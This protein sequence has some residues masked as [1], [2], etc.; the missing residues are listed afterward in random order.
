MGNKTSAPKETP[1]VTK[2]DEK[3]IIRAGARA[4]AP[5]PSDVDVA[6]YFSR[7]ACSSKVP[8]VIDYRDEFFKHFPCRD[9]GSRSTC[10][11]QCGAYIKQ[12][13]ELKETGKAMLFSPDYIYDLRENA[14]IRG[15]SEGM[16]GRDLMRILTQYGAAL[17][18][19]Y[20]SKYHNK[21]NIPESVHRK[22]KP[23]RLRGYARVETMSELKR[24]LYHNGPCMIIIPVY[25][26][27]SQPWV[28][29]YKGQ[30]WRE[31]HAVTVIGYNEK[32]FIILNSWGRDWADNGCTI[33]PYSHWTMKPNIYV[34]HVNKDECP[35]EVWTM[36]DD[37]NKY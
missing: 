12:W 37:R 18:K 35:F 36:I 14:H 25:N 4:S 28:P 7:R 29:E 31:I 26:D 9:Q 5:S 33:F 17:E 15:E 21:F 23:Y 19:H 27:S 30:K 8:K 24:S 34:S 2:S 13:Q 6:E 20:P 3:K 11:A 32:G 22:A 16:T 10:V 1:P